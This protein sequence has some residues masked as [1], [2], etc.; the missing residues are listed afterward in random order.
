MLSDRRMELVAPRTQCGLDAGVA[1]DDPG[2]DVA[3]TVALLVALSSPDRRR[4]AAAASRPLSLSPGRARL[5]TTFATIGESHEG[6]GAR[7]GPQIADGNGPGRGRLDRRQGQHPARG[8]TQGRPHTVVGR[9]QRVIGGGGSR[10]VHGHRRDG[11]RRVLGLRSG[12]LAQP[13]SGRRDQPSDRV[14]HRTRHH[15]RTRPWS[16]AHRHHPMGRSALRTGEDGSAT[17]YDLSAPS[18]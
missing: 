17:V 5:R 1:M 16:P 3:A 2:R 11:D 18:H 15:P 12:A 7:V 10:V 13:V 14:L 9:D 8:S 6:G 4:L